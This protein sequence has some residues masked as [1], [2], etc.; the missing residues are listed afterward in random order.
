M[1]NSEKVYKSEGAEAAVVKYRT[2]LQRMRPNLVS[3]AA[4][5]R[6][7]FKLLDHILRTD[8]PQHPN[9]PNRPHPLHDDTN[10][11]LNNRV[12]REV[13][14]GSGVVVWDSTLPLSHLYAKECLTRNLNTP[15]RYYWKCNDH[16]HVGFILSDQ[17][18]NMIVNDYCNAYLDL[19]VEY[20]GQ[21]H[22]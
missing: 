10:F 6:V 1:Y 19:G 15:P 5:T 8:I 20:C 4:Q 17:Y 13:L 9:R 7:V 2:A 12:A 11:D 3:L 21:E 18:A 22:T 16:N 14:N